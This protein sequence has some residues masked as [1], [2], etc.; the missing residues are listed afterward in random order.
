MYGIVFIYNLEIVK[1]DK[2]HLKIKVIEYFIMFN[3]DPIQK[4]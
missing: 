4:L 2:Y 3:E 1:Y